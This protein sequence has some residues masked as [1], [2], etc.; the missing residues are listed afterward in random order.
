MADCL[1]PE[2]LKVEQCRGPYKRDPETPQCDHCARL[3]GVVIPE[4]RDYV[5]ARRKSVSDLSEIKG[6]SMGRLTK[7]WSLRVETIVVEL[8]SQV[9]DT[10]FPPIFALCMAGSGGRF[11]AC[12]YSDIDAFILVDRKEDAQTFIAASKRVSSILT[13]LGGKESGFQFCSGGMNPI[14]HTRTPEAMAQT[15][16]STKDGH[17][18]AALRQCRFAFGMRGLYDEYIALV[19][20]GRLVTDTDAARRRG[21]EMLKTLLSNRASMHPAVRASDA[22]VHVKN[23]LYRPLQLMVQGLHVY[24]GGA[25]HIIDIRQQIAARAADGHVSVPVATLV[26]NLLEDLT[27]LRFAAHSTAQREAELIALTHLAPPKAVT[28]VLA[29][30]DPTVRACIVNMDILWKLATAFVREQTKRIG[31]KKNPFAAENLAAYR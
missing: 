2:R 5:T 22:T 8:Y 17:A 20:G 7:E 13:T 16:G 21:L 30:L 12:P 18:A 25:E 10:T 15:L 14:F 27:R 29:H 31:F 4:S 6:L 23:Q 26:T 11:E 19:Q 1:A 24:F 28:P 9:L 3:A